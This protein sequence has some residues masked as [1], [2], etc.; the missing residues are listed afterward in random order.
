MTSYCL[1]EK[2][3][4]DGIWYAFG[5]WENTS[6]EE[7][8]TIIYIIIITIISSGSNSNSSSEDIKSYVL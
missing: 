8:R 7:L 6:H 4:N 5:Y 3:D 2:H 1:Y